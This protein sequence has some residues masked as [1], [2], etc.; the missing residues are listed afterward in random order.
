M[1]K[2]RSVIP[3]SNASW[4]DKLLG[5]L[6][7]TKLTRVLVYVCP[8]CRARLNSKGEM[9]YG[10]DSCPKCSATY[11]FDDEIKSAYSLFEAELAQKKKEEEQKDKEREQQVLARET[12][13]RIRRNEKVA[14]EAAQAEINRKKVQDELDRTAWSQIGKNRF[15][16]ESFLLVR[17]QAAWGRLNILIQGTRACLIMLLLV[18]LV[19]MIAPDDS[20]RLFQS[21]TAIFWSC[22]PALISLE[23]FGFLVNVAVSIP[24]LLFRIL[25]EM[26]A[27]NN[28]H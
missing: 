24:Y 5:G 19:M 17:V 8:K 6:L 27:H 26:T 18:S 22:I 4:E 15:A 11:Y 2:Q 9:I 23:I 12:Q 25:E 14:Q 16:S 21:G 13:A 10:G 20:W 1:S 28:N 7:S 3:A